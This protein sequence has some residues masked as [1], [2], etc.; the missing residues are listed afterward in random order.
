MRSLDS[1]RYRMVKK[2]IHRAETFRRKAKSYAEVDAW[3][4]VEVWLRTLI[5]KGRYQDKNGV[6]KM[7]EPKEEDLNEPEEQVQEST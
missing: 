2:W 1:F 5:S 7:R 4:K 3:D 6:I